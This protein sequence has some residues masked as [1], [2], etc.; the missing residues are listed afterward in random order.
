MGYGDQTG[1]QRPTQLRLFFSLSLN[2]LGQLE[3]LSPEQVVA[4]FP[5]AAPEVQHQ[6]LSLPQSAQ[7]LLSLHPILSPSATALDTVSEKLEAALESLSLAL[8]NQLPND[9]S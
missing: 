5:L 9:Q 6:A 3:A 1:A 4:S 7:H 8:W 2:S